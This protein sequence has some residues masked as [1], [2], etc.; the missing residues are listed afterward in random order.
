M[1][2]N[3]SCVSWSPLSAF[4]SLFFFRSLTTQPLWWR[5]RAREHKFEQR[6]KTRHEDVPEAFVLTPMV[7][8]VVYLETK[9]YCFV[10][11]IVSSIPL[12]RRW[13]RWR[14]R[15]GRELI[16]DCLIFRHIVA[17]CCVVH[18]SHFAVYSPVQTEWQREPANFDTTIYA[19]YKRILDA[20]FN[21][22][23]RT[24]K[25]Q[26]AGIYLW[27]SYN[28]HFS[29]DRCKRKEEKIKSNYRADIKFKLHAKRR[30]RKER[31]GGKRK[32][33]NL[34]LKIF[35]FVGFDCQSHHLRLR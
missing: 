30:E 16:V 24:E 7:L 17:V 18:S 31:A 25:R 2:V 20:E 21:R 28:H 10:G 13:R 4:F 6:P 19:K 26:T 14:H 8:S 33:R 22:S 35:L 32:R 3:E 1:C 12:R 5:S 11:C 15:H 34:V 27:Q 29:S 9:N 23:R